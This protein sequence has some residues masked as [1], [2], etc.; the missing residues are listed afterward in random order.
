MRK[1]SKYMKLL[2]LMSMGIWMTF[3]AAFNVYWIVFSGLNVAIMNVL[4]YDKIR[5]GYF[6]IPDFLPG[7][8][9]E[10]LNVGY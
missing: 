1:I 10:R 8:K 7:T 4:R 3:P 9:L 5:T 2:P 6:G